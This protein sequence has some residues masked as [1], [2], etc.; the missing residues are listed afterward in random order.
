MAIQK[1]PHPNTQQNT[2]PEQSD[3]EANEQEYEAD[4]P[5]DQEIYQKTDGAETGMDRN[6]RGTETRS[7]RRR[8][9]PE[10]EAHEGGVSSRTLKRQS[11]GITARMAEEESKRQEKVVKD[12]ADA[13]AG[14]NR[15]RR[16]KAS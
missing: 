4:S 16:K 14:V 7:E 6:P 3:L 1:S 8:I 15:T 5:Q 10:Q 13:Q 9:E 11:Q 2:K 12:R